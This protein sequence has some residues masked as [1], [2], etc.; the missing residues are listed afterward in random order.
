MKTAFSVLILCFLFRIP[1][2]SQEAQKFDEFIGTPC[3]DYLAR[4]DNVL[5]QARDNP[6]L[7]VY[8]LIYEGKE[9]V[10]NRRKKGMEWT[11]PTYGSTEAKIRSMKKYMSYRKMP[12]ERFSFVKAGFRE[13]STVEIWLVPPGISPPTPTPTLTKMKYRKGKP[14]RF[15]T[16]CCL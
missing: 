3:E 14:A 10:F 15:C 16:N 4:M 13:N 1:A 12:A 5:A 2:F 8:V 9:L 11:V 6:L 7:T